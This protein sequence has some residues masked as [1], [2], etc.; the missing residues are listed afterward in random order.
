MGAA[1]E[2]PMS[3]PREPYKPLRLVHKTLDIVEKLSRA[4]GA[5]HKSDALSYQVIE[6]FLEASA[7]DDVASEAV[8]EAV[9]NLR[10]FFGKLAQA[11]EKV[12]RGG[13]LP[14]DR[15]SPDA[16]AASEIQST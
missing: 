6:F 13:E 10:D 12:S 9:F 2:A 7:P 14:A 15:T 8:Q 11:N 3:E 1:A 16:V 5:S 4:T